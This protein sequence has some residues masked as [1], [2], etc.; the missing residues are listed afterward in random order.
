MNFQ[1]ELELLIRA[2]YPVINIVS[3]EETRVRNDVVE[4]ANKRRKKVFE[5]SCTTGIAPAGTSLQAVERA[6][7]LG[8]LPKTALETA[9][10]APQSA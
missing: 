6:V 3:N 7:R 10:P 8:R 9:T 5:W 4:A 1:D 2:R